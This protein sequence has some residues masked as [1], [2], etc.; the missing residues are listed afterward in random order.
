M[1]R[2]RPRTPDQEVAIG[3]CAAEAQE[4]ALGERIRLRRPLG[5]DRSSVL[6]VLV[7]G[8]AMKSK[9]KTDLHGSLRQSQAK[10]KRLM[11]LER[12]DESG[13]IEKNFQPRSLR[14]FESC[15]QPKNW[16]SPAPDGRQ[17]PMDLLSIA[18]RNNAAIDVIERL[19]CFAGTC[20]G[21]GCG[22]AIQ[23]RWRTLR[24]KSWE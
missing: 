15:Q 8:G 9:L 16:F 1:R 7:E 5:N 6:P 10:K 21:A 13:I 14:R 4:Q 20:D 12:R 11:P 17:T 3:R 22:A 19:S 2:D 23:Y 18:L 24:S